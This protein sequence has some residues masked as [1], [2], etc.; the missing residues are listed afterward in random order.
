MNEFGGMDNV[1]V[2]MVQPLR[3]AGAEGQLLALRA[4][5]VMR[6]NAFHNTA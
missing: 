6:L 2:E 1:S 3:R 4:S 5:V